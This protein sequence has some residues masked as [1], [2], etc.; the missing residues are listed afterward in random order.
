VRFLLWNSV[1]G[2]VGSTSAV[3]RSSLAAGILTSNE[4]SGYEGGTK[5]E[6]DTVCQFIQK[7]IAGDQ[8]DQRFPEVIYTQQHGGGL[9]GIWPKGVR[10]NWEGSRAAT[11]RSS[12]ECLR[13]PL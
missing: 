11:V 12:V 4:M 10:P 9:L 8:E 13:H 3:S 6:G 1:S 7:R 5:E 2:E